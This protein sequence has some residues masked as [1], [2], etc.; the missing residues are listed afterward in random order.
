MATAEAKFYYWALF[1]YCYFIN[2]S[3]MVYAGGPNLLSHRHQK[4]GFYTATA[5]H[6]FLENIRCKQK[7]KIVY[8]KKLNFSLSVIFNKIIVTFLDE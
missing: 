7:L 8:K 1:F 2:L 4:T 3:K 6:S 5:A